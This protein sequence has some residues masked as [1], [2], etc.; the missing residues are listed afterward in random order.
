MYFSL[1][2]YITIDDHYNIYYDFEVDE[3]SLDII[4]L[5]P[6][7]KIVIPQSY[8]NLCGIDENGKEDD[9]NDDNYLNF[10]KIS[11]SESSE[12]LQM[13]F[14]SNEDEIKSNEDMDKYYNEI[15]SIFKKHQ[16]QVNNCKDLEKIYLR[17]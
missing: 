8:E 6:E 4:L 11:I 10:K 17:N 15:I 9:V 12:V 1:L 14:M 2:Y 3:D 7:F 16:Y 13:L 5:T